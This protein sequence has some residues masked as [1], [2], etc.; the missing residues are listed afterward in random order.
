MVHIGFWRHKHY[1]EKHK[2]LLI[3]NNK[4]GLEV[5]AV[6][7]KYRLMFHWQILENVQSL[8]I[9]KWH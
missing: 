8:N 7:T 4:V 6:K 3:V 2:V 1:V 5:N 9:C